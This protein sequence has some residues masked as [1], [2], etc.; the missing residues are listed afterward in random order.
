M[1][2]IWF[3]WAVLLLASGVALSSQ[4]QSPRAEQQTP[5]TIQSR[6]QAAYQSYLQHAEQQ[7]FEA[8]LPHAQDAYLLGRS[9]VGADTEDFA[10][11]TYNYGL[12]LLETGAAHR[13][14]PILQSALQQYESL[15]GKH[16]FKLAP[17]LAHLATAAAM[18]GEADLARSHFDRGIAILREL[19]GEES[20]PVATLS[21]HAGIA[22][23]ESA[24]FAQA[25]RYLH[26][27]YAIHRDR[28][29]TADRNAALAS[30]YLGQTW[31]AED[32][33]AAAIPHLKAALKGFELSAEADRQYALDTHVSLVV[34][35]ENLGR[36]DAAT[37][38]CLAVG[39][40]LPEV[41]AS[42]FR[43]LFEPVPEYPAEALSS[44]SQATITVEFQVDER[45]FVRNLEAIDV[46]GDN[47]F[48][49]PA[50]DAASRFRFAPRFVDGRPVAA[51]HVQARLS[52]VPP[53]QE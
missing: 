30:F 34:A 1:L 8:A 18:S 38:H 27:S 23:T 47:I 39:K 26:S 21:L 13:A 25:R 31:L 44:S 42:G 49:E 17:L 2:R 33:W 32:E 37:E 48:V 9:I 12:S 46:Q 52:F 24:D 51:E 29:G 50:L 15:F 22:L 20:L 19:H 10:N 28:V 11:L 53:Q 6:Y 45:G 35:Y 16:A 36:S 41:Y 7:N 40:S 4:A 43:P 14:Y 5:A 3:G